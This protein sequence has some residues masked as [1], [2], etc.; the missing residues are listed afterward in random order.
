MAWEYK[1][2]KA[3]TGRQIRRRGGEKWRLQLRWLEDVKLELR[4]VGVKMRTR[5][6]DRPEWPSV[7]KGCT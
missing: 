4:N 7:M 5:A 6:L 2:S 3:V 1:D